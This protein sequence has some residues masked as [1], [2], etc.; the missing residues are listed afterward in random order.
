MGFRVLM[1]KWHKALLAIVLIGFVLSCAA[2]F[3]RVY[4]ATKYVSD[5]CAKRQI[6]CDLTIKELTRTHLDIDELIISDDMGLETRIKGLQAS[7][8]NIFSAFELL[9]ISI[10][11]F[12]GDLVV[13]A[14]GDIQNSLLKAVQFAP[15]SQPGQTLQLQNIPELNIETLKLAFEAPQFSAQLSS[16]WLEVTKSRSNTDDSLEVTGILELAHVQPRESGIKAIRFPAVLGFIANMNQNVQGVLSVTD[17]W[18]SLETTGLA[19]ETQDVSFE[20]G[21]LIAELITGPNY[22][23]PKLDLALGGDKVRFKQMSELEF[24]HIDL[25][26]E[27]PCLPKVDSNKGVTWPSLSACLAVDEPMTFDFSGVVGSH[28]SVNRGELN[29]LA[30]HDQVAITTYLQKLRY[31]GLQTKSLLAWV[32]LPHDK[33]SAALRCFIERNRSCLVPLDEAPFKL[34][35]KGAG[36]PDHALSVIGNV[37]FDGQL[38]LMTALGR[39]QQSL[40]TY[41]HYDIELV[42]EIDFTTLAPNLIFKEINVQNEKAPLQISLKGEDGMAL[43]GLNEE[44]LVINDA[45]LSIKYGDELALKTK[46]S[47]TINRNE[48]F[49]VVL[50]DY[51]LNL[52]STKEAFNIMGDRVTATYMDGILNIA[53]VPDITYSGRGPAFDIAR[54]HLHLPINFTSKSA[55]SDISL[56]ACARVSTKGL[57]WGAAHLTQQVFEV[58]PKQ[59]ANLRSSSKQGFEVSW[60]DVEASMPELTYSTVDAKL[61]AQLSDAPWTVYYDKHKLL[62]KSAEARLHLEMS[63][64]TLSTHLKDIEI[65]AGLDGNLK[66]AYFQL[67]SF[68]GRQLPIML[69]NGNVIIEPQGSQILPLR[70]ALNNIHIKEAEHIET[71]DAFHPVGFSGQMKVTKEGFGA[72]GVVELLTPLTRL[73]QVTLSHDMASGQG[74]MGF[75]GDL[76]FFQEDHLQPHNISEI[77]RGVFTNAIGTVTLNAKAGWNADGFDTSGELEIKDMDFASVLGPVDGMNGTIAFKDLL[78][79]ETYPSQRITMGTITPGLPLYDGVIDFQF[80]SA[81]AIKV[82]SLSWPFADGY[83]IAEPF[84][85]EF[86]DH[87]HYLTLKAERWDLDVLFA[88]LGLNDIEVTGRVS[89]NIPLVSQTGGVII[90]DASL[91]TSADGGVIRYKPAYGEAAGENNEF[92]KLTFEALE[93][94]RYRLLSLGLSGDLAGRM[95][96]KLAVEGHNPAVYSGSDIKL[97]VTLETALMSLFNQVALVTSGDKAFEAYLAETGGQR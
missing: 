10:K 75:E 65:R 91:F 45:P 78:A 59:A 36:L 23:A 33:L 9:D 54:T 28:L 84:K 90:N 27:M 63:D 92:V 18:A 2:Y 73:G 13:T 24:A 94:F 8:H 5:I 37:Q 42:G 76:L 17:F 16:D 6:K 40:T 4:I 49:R 88:E 71:L 60:K 46:L 12:G 52:A 25:D 79:L 89:G 32:G 67:S 31:Q 51:H 87:E 14:D 96:V 11:H 93:D 39:F 7:Y 68:G 86:G 19:F 55:Q 48:T 62:A 83:I 1:K 15:S 50:A 80:L 21:Y 77:M 34:T 85:W 53:G 44:G 56:N 35:L 69:Q 20:E 41:S 43:G 30:K 97:Q 72:S 64:D 29:L 58:C 38:P 70:I 82:E 61:N 66:G 26:V 57:Q 95:I 74:E 3:S 22:Q 81:E 47:A